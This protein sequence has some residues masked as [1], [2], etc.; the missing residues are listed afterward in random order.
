MS[1]GQPLLA[2]EGLSVSFPV[3]GS[4]QRAVDEISLELIR[5]QTLAL[6]GESGSG[7]SVLALA[8]LRLIEPPGEIDGGQIRFGAEELLAAPEARMLELRGNR[9][10]VIFQ[11]P[12]TALNPVM[13]IG[14]QVSE[15][16]R[17]HRRLGNQEA[18]DRAVEL[19]AEVG[20]PDPAE[21]QDAF[22]HQLS[23]G[24]CQRV[25]IAMALA[26]SPEILIADEPTTALDVATQSQIL[27]LLRRLQRSRDMALLFITHDLSLLGMIADEVAVIY[28][29]R[30][31][32]RNRV[33]DFIRRARHPYAEALKRSSPSGKKGERLAMIPGSVPSLGK[34]PAGCAFAPRCS[35]TRQRCRAERPELDH[36]VACFYPLGNEE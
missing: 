27:R 28:A 36:G 34:I 8:L 10:A 3:G 6:V 33:R 22:A 18:R 16:L 4:R 9:I 32:E 5:G 11:E 30:I 15:P 31:V 26:C 13:R 17:V 20:I 2:V 25:V 12:M 29:G 35:H 21:A 24:M 14:A 7:K 1:A 19:L 23:G